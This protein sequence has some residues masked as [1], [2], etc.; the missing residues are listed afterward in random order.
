MKV[1]KNSLGN[2]YC[3][4]RKVFERH[5]SKNILKDLRDDGIR[6]QTLLK[7]VLMNYLWAKNDQQLQMYPLDHSI[8]HATSSHEK[9]QSRNPSGENMHPEWKSYH[10]HR[11]SPELPPAMEQ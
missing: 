6:I 1:V 9:H 7:R 2:R 4:Y 8:A 5:S 10:A 3:Q 11:Y